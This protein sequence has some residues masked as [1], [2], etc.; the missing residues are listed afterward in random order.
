MVEHL[1]FLKDFDERLTTCFDFVLDHLDDLALDRQLLDAIE[2]GA[3]VLFQRALDQL[4]NQ[5]DL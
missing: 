5:H 3:L 4:L 2:T 1:V